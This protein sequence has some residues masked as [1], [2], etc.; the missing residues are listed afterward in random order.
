MSRSETQHPSGTGTTEGRP[1]SI[2][3][4]RNFLRL[5]TG[6]TVSLLGSTI[7]GFAIAVVAVVTLHASP[8]RSR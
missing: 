2:L 6:E 5:W 8:A 7:T 1:R 4:D 3:R